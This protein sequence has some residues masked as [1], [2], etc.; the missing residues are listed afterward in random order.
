MGSKK[1]G[2][3]GHNK[4]QNEKD[5]TAGFLLSTISLFPQSTGQKLHAVKP[6]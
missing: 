1:A 5:R 2:S 6:Q 4:D 3:P